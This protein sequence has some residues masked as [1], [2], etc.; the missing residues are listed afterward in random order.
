[1]T[2]EST[3]SRNHLQG[4]TMLQ[5]KISRRFP[6]FRYLVIP[7]LALAGVGTAI[8]TVIAQVPSTATPQAMSTPPRSPFENRIAGIG[9]VLPSSDVISVGTV[10]AGIVE[11]VS[12]TDGQ[13]VKKGETLFRIDGRQTRADLAVSRAKLE[14]ARASLASVVA[15]PR[16]PTMQDADARVAAARAQVTDAQGRLAR[17]VEL[18]PEAATSPNELPRLEYEAAL[19]TSALEEAEAHRDEVKGGAWPEDLLVAKGE[20]D[21]AA[22][23]VARLETQLERETLRAPFDSTVLYVDIDPGE[24]VVPGS[25]QQMVAVGVLDPLHVRVQ[26]DEIDAWR[27]KPDSKAVAIPRGGAPGEFTLK[28]LR[29]I[30][31]I[32]PKKLLSG[33]SAERVD[34]RILE[35]EYEL[36]NPGTMALLAGQVVDVFIAAGTD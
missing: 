16:K 14:V 10:L 28:F 17:L 36:A 7:V 26:I 5:P 27:F 23:E 12:V 6:P 30:P 4:S 15:L 21:V 3:A 31:L 24:H 32:V 2:D 34:V 35:I 8:Y 11:E 18:G 9:T 33:D 22:A 1:M 19:A 20:V 13:V 25:V 29:V